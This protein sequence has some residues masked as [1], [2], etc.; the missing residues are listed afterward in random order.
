MVTCGSTTTSETSTSITGFPQ[1]QRERE[2]DGPLLFFCG[3][4]GDVEAFAN[5]SGFLRE[6]AA[7]WRPWST[8]PQMYPW[9]VMSMNWV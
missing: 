8:G 9:D 5:F 4:E 2:R 6:A 7:P 3:N 1:A